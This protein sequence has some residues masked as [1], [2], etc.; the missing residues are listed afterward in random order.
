M[1]YYNTLVVPFVDYYSTLINLPFCHF[2]KVFTLPE[3]KILI[4]GRSGSGKTTLLRKIHK[5]YSKL[6]TISKFMSDVDFQFISDF[7]VNQWD[8]IIEFYIQEQQC[9]DLDTQDLV[10][11]N[12]RD[13]KNILITIDE[14]WLNRKHYYKLLS[15]LKMS[16]CCKVGM[17]IVL[18]KLDEFNLLSSEF[19]YIIEQFTMS[20]YNYQLTDVKNNKKYWIN[21]KFL[22]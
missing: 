5:Y 21:S 10:I 20:G 2:N 13:T 19:D 11:H 16:S 6:H 4:F 15:T 8:L 18:S 7:M 14:I 1:F 12:E 17:I 22:E 9:C 3:K